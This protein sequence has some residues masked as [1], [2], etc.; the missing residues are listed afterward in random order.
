MIQTLVIYFFNFYFILLFYYF[1]VSSEGELFAVAQR[2]RFW[3]ILSKKKKKRG[4]RKMKTIRVQS[5][6]CAASSVVLTYAVCSR[7]DT[8]TTNQK[9]KILI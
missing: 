2:V 7:K 5:S 8:E 4:Q 9:E 3:P 1:T 6:F